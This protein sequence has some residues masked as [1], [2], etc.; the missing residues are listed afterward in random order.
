[1][2]QTPCTPQGVSAHVWFSRG[3]LVVGK[4]V[5]DG[6]LSVA[7]AEAE[8]EIRDGCSEENGIGGVTTIE[9][10][11]EADGIVGVGNI[12]GTT[13]ELWNKVE[14]AGTITVV[15]EPSNTTGSDSE[16]APRGTE[17]DTIVADA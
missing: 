8:G 10:T 14:L 5:D 2:V 15:L 13:A 7:E 6:V 11:D 12:D 17:E 4:T 16:E 9:L 3:G 1:M